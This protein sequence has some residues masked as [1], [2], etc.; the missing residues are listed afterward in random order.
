MDS[1]SSSPIQPPVRPFRSTFVSGLAIFSLVAAVFFVFSDLFGI[2]SYI[3]LTNSSEYRMAMQMMQKYQ[4][5]MG[6]M[7]FNTQWM[8]TTSI[9]SLILNG[10]TIVAS[11]GLF[12]R[13][14]WGRI[15]FISLALIQAAYYVGSAVVGYYL[16]RS[17]TEQS[18]IGSLLGTLGASG[19]LEFGGIA[20]FFSAAVAVAI[21][22]F[23]VWKLSSKKIRE[24]FA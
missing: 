2:F 13:K 15:S 7:L 11:I 16:A 3:S 10:G 24:E 17:L 14:N 1:H 22:V 21:A 20:A 6:S 23:V 18:G 9:I 19:L 5:A 8:I 4:P 12:R